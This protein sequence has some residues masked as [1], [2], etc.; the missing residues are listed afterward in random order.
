MSRNRDT[1]CSVGMTNLGNHTGRASSSASIVVVVVVV[2]VV[3]RVALVV[4]L[5]AVGVTI[6]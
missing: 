1:G 5:E 6:L 2:V 3:R 4:V